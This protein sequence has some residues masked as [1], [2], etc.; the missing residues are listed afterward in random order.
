MGPWHL[1]ARVCHS[2]DLVRIGYNTWSLAT[3]PYQAFIPRLAEIG[4]SAIAIS[5][6][7]GYTI[8]ERYVANACDQ[9]SLSADDR[10]RIKEGLRQRGFVLTSVVGNQ[11][12]L[13]SDSDRVEAG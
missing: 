3:V 13:H 7:A 2:G 8:G 10:R 4:Y 9:A 5:V 1:S 11:P 6:I 12:L